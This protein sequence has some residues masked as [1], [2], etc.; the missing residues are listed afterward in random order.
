MSLTQKVLVSVFIVIGINVSCLAADTKF[1]K[2][3]LS[4]GV[5]YFHDVEVGIVDGVMLKME[6]ATP[7]RVKSSEPRAVVALIHGGGWRRGD[8]NKF[9]KSVVGLAKRG[10]V[11]A[12][13]MYRLS[14]EHKFPAQV[15]DVMTGIRYLKSNAKKYHLDPTKIVVRGGSAG[16]HLAAMLGVASKSDRFKKHGL[17]TDVDSTVRGVINFYGPTSLFLTERSAGHKSITLFLGAPST[18]IPDVATAAMPITY[19][20][21]NSAAFFIVQGDND[22]SVPVEMNRKFAKA[23][24]EH[25]V[26]YEYHEVKGGTH[27]LSKSNP[28]EYK[29]LKEKS[30]AFIERVTADGGAANVIIRQ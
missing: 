19:V 7:P 9:A 3:K 8:K 15:E 2:P 4:K 30:Y 12:S 11:G 21:N 6:I 18:S 29:R 20:D 26:S 27:K 10:Y 24:A 13:L 14:P 1:V 5:T 22:K 16:G 17:W 25:N 23:L 28:E